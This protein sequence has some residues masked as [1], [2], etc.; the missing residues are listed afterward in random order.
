M[1]KEIVIDE[2][3]SHLPGWVC[4][5]DADQKS[6]V[7]IELF[8]DEQ[9]EETRKIAEMAED[10]Y[11]FKGI[12]V[13]FRK[14]LAVVKLDRVVGEPNLKASIALKEYAEAVGFEKIWIRGSHSIK[15]T[16]KRHEKV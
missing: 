11:T 13:N 8:T 9:I 16:A 5:M 1:N 15:F 2:Q 7:N 12:Y 4:R 10:I 14:N 6:A 3:K